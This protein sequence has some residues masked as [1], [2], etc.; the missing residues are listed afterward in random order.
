MEAES[1]KLLKEKKTGQPKGEERGR[2]KC[3]NSDCPCVD[4]E[5]VRDQLH[6]LDIGKSMCPEE[7]FLYCLLQH[8]SGEV[9]QLCDE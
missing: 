2:D 1:R 5:I 8:P 6:Q 9:A 4:T 7:A 3:R